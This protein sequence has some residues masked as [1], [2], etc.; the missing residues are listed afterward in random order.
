MLVYL[1]KG[2]TYMVPALQV[3][4]RH[5][6]SIS[7]QARSGYTNWL[8]KQALC[9][10]LSV[11]TLPEMLFRGV[12][13]SQPISR[14]YRLYWNGDPTKAISFAYVKFGYGVSWG[15]SNGRQP[16][17]LTTRSMLQPLTMPMIWPLKQI[18]RRPFL[19]QRIALS[20]KS[21]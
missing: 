17:V 9:Q 21:G 6:V 19:R 18:S 2:A 7:R 15:P 4:P 11:A 8:L 20:K 16:L 5:L 10:T 12:S 13:R 1:V 14:V 3:L